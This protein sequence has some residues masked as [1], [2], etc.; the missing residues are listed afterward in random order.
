MDALTDRL[1]EVA[2]NLHG[3]AQCMCGQS[4]VGAIP[5]DGP[6]G[7]EVFCP[8]CHVSAFIQFSDPTEVTEDAVLAQ[9]VA[10]GNPEPEPA[11]HSE[12]AEPAGC[13]EY[14]G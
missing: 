13:P 9:F 14:D 8:K 10:A 12:S 1:G 6:Y 4:C 7:I 3:Y 5:Y 11:G 2:Y